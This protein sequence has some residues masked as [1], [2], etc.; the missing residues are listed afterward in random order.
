MTGSRGGDPSSTLID[1]AIA[2]PSFMANLG[3]WMDS[4]LAH[5]T[6]SEARASGFLDAASSQNGDILDDFDICYCVD[7][8]ISANATMQVKLIWVSSLDGCSTSSID[9]ILQ[10]Q[11][12][13]L[14][15]CEAFLGCGKCIHKSGYVVIVISMCREMVSGI[16]T[17]QRITS[18]EPS[19]S[20]SPPQSG[21]PRRPSN[22]GSSVER[23]SSQDNSYLGAGGWHL[24]DDDEVEIIRNL[25]QVRIKKLKKLID[26]LELVVMT[27]HASYI[28]IV[29]SLRDILDD[30]L[31]LTAPQTGV[32]MAL[33]G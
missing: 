17:L 27:N 18:P 6:H 30:K 4:G 21:A 33:N 16:K 9:D 11:K 23:S 15:S 3:A 31:D 14:A 1:S 32:T 10:C 29:G 13:V 2:T 20:S 8:I 19:S 7:R 12:N 24:D 26:L 5:D 28:W 25:I 22:G